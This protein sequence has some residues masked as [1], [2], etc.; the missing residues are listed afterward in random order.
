MRRTRR[1]KLDDFDLRLIITGLHKTLEDVPAENKYDAAELI[2]RLID[3]D[4]ALK[5]GRKKKVSFEPEQRSHIMRSLLAWRNIVLEDD[6][7]T[8]DIDAMIILFSK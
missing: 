5:C 4:K 2:L 8:E 7:P 3:I 6:G 1:V